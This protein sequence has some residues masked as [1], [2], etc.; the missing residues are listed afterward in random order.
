MQDKAVDE[1]KMLGRCWNYLEITILATVYGR[2]K[3]DGEI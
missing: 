1:D 3:E 2:I